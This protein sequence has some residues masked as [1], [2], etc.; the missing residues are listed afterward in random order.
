MRHAVPTAG[1]LGRRGWTIVAVLVAS[2]LSI[3]NW[4]HRL[5]QNLTDREVL[6]TMKFLLI[7]VV[8]LP[9]LPSKPIDPWGVYN[10]QELWFLVVL[11]SGI[12]FAGYFA[13]RFMGRDHGLAVTGALGGLASS[14][15]VTLAMS[16]RAGR[17]ADDRAVNVAAAFGILVASGIMTVRV[18]FIVAAVAPK[19]VAP[20]AL[21]VLAMAIPGVGVAGYFWTQMG[22]DRTMPAEPEGPESSETV[23]E[24]TDADDLEIE[25]PFEL[26]PALKFGLLFVVIIGGV[27]FA[28]RGFG[29]YGTYIAAF[30]SGLANMDA[31]SLEMGRMLEAGDIGTTVA[32][33]GVV[34]AI[35]AN[36]FSKAVLSATIGSKKLGIYV[37]AG[38]IPMAVVGLGMVT[39][40]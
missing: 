25:N 17:A 26:T 12:S 21:P 23:G 10:L 14:T 1:S 36:S 32:V 2:I 3:K 40:V 29:D 7:S 22:A 39:L 6:G 11:V 35:I 19:I 15:A 34:I 27:H 8:L 38:L 28:R 16:Q 37:T 9:L 4:T 18:L 31:I 20:L 33:R 5:V 13:M 30:V 24:S